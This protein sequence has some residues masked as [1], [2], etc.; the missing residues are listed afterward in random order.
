MVQLTIIQILLTLVG[1]EEIVKAHERWRDR[2]Q[3]TVSYTKKKWVRALN[4]ALEKKLV[5]LK[6]MKNVDYTHNKYEDLCK[7]I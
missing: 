1:V 5:L 3:E 6:V 4:E 2:L 7:W